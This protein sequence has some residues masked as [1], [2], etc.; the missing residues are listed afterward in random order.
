MINEEWKDIKGF[1]GIYQISNY[2][3]IKSLIRNKIRKLTINRDGYIVISLRKKFFQIHRLV[4]ST[5][6]PINLFMECNHIDGNKLNNKLDNLEWVTRSKNQ[7]HAFKKGL[8]YRKLSTNDI[9]M[10]KNIY[11]K[12]NITQKELG[13]IYNISRTMITRIINETRYKE[14]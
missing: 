1:E 2:G 4:L 5:F 13:K 14:G 7:L 3:R 12:G 10:I 6:Y 9:I 8:Q 11:S